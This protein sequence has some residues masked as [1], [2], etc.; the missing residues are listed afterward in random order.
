MKQTERNVV[1][2]RRRISWLDRLLAL[3][4]IGTCLALAAGVFVLWPAY[5][6]PQSRMYSSALGYLK[7]QRMLGLKLSAEA[8]H[9]AYHDF[10]TPILGEGMVQCDFYNVPVVPTTRVKRLLVEEGDQIKKGQVLAELDDIQAQLKYRVAE[11]A[12]ASAKSQLQRVMAGSVNTM[13]AERPEKDKADLA[14]MQKVVKSARD[15]VRMYKQMEKDGASSKLE[16]V[17]AEIEL[18]ND[19]TN[20]EQAKISTGMSNQGFP[21]S[22]EIAQDAVDDAQNLLQQRA[23]EL[24]YYHVVAPVD[25]VVDR[26]LIRNGEFNQATGNTGFILASDTWFEANLDQRALGD[27]QEGMEATVNFESYPGHTFDATVE[28][29]IPIV[30]FDAGGP[31]TKTPVRPLGTGTPEWPATFRVRLRLASADV[32]V[33]PGMT[34]FARLAAH[35]NKTLAVRR[36]AVSSL[37]SGKGVVRVVDNSGR[38]VTTPV[39]IGAVDDEFVQILSGLDESDWVLKDNS[40]FLRDDDK[41]HVTRV[42]AAKE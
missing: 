13:E 40:R 41:I 3:L 29:V 20:L 4:V 42:V 33:A 10:E 28:R 22:K 21:G 14:G 27:V 23:D 8:E 9:P 16:L 5:T 7:V 37:S 12:L 26:V 2:S 6:N 24:N 38:L 31:E 34:G 30:T 17:N 32:R 15:K 25:G 18:A 11:T 39:T 35:R 36:D 1:N 19:E